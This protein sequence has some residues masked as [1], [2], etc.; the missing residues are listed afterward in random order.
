MKNN[1][2]VLELEVETERDGNLYVPYSGLTLRGRK[3]FARIAR[4]R[5]KAAELL[6]DF[7]AGI[8]GSRVRIDL[9]EGRVF[10][11]EPLQ[12]E[13]YQTERLKLERLGHQIPRTAEM[14]DTSVSGWLHEMNRAV[15][16]GCARVVSGKF[17]SDLGPEPDAPSKFEDQQE[18]QGDKFDT[19]C[20]LLEQLLGRLAPASIK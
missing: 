18:P 14:K 13:E 20:N 16:A 3:D 2:N 15:N 9:D 19:L 4:S 11:V 6:G 7:P 10:V 8:P 5:V 12:S 1:G 17:P